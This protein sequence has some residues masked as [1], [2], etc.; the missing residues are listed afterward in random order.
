MRQSFLTTT[1]AALLVLAAHEAWATTRYVALSGDNSDGLS[2]AT[3]RTALQTAVD[4]AASDDV[5]CIKTGVYVLASQIDINAK[6]LTIRG[7]YEGSGSP[8]ARSDDASLT[9]LDGNL[10]TRVM[11]AVNCATGLVEGLTIARGIIAASGSGI[12][13]SNTTNTFR[14]CIVRDN[15]LTS[16][17]GAAVYYENGGTVTFESCVIRNSKL[18]GPSNTYGGA[19][20]KVV[21]D[22][23]L[24]NCI[25]AGN[26]GYCS[27]IYVTNTGEV[28]AFNCLFRNNTAGHQTVGSI[29]N[30]NGTMWLENCTVESSGPMGVYRAGGTVVVTN[31]IVWN[32]GG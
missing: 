27:A 16:G 7:G 13:L 26:R 32:N 21:G 15:D 9:V 12:Y 22:L 10:A 20:Y 17:A 4:D 30:N 3:A 11:S 25:V 18:T 5:I 6:N 31:S 23:T 28:R 1:V 19:F 2:W 24:R 29:R 14:N 8:G